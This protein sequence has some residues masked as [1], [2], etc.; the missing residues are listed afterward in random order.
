M[1]HK[2][3]LTI[4]LDNYS[5]CLVALE[6]AQQSAE[7]SHAVN[8]QQRYADARADL[9]AAFIRALTEEFSHE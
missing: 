1:T 5:C 6:L 8:A 9:K 4:A 3:T 7:W 2:I